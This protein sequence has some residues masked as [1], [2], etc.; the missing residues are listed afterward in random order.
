MIRTSINPG[1]MVNSLLSNHRLIWKMICREIASKYKTS[2]AGVMWSFLNPLIMLGIYTFVFN[3]IFKARWNTGPDS[4]TNFALMIFIGMIIHGVLAETIAG[5]PNL[6]VRNT[7]YVKKVIFPIEILPLVSI[8]V[9]LFHALISFFIWSILFIITVGQ[10]RITALFIPVLIIPLLCFSLSISWL[11]AAIGVYFRDVDQMTNVVN[12]LLL[13]TSPVVYPLTHIPTNIQIYFYAN[14]LTF[15]IEQ[16]RSILIYGIPPNWYS[17]GVIL[18]S[19]I[20]AAWLGFAFF[21]KT[22]HGFADVL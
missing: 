19:S 15:I 3:I 1:G 21:Q 12:A 6:I 5:S 18:F 10:F 7:N 4:T 13:F 11:L 20:L 17:L 9:T 8:G 14:P 22:R 2:I 16:T